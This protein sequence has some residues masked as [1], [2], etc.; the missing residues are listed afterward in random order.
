MNID[1]QQ[2]VDLFVD[3]MKVALPLGTVWAILER[4]V[5]MYYDAVSDRWVRKR[6]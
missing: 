3:L 2:A 5:E 4:L 6:E 1:Y